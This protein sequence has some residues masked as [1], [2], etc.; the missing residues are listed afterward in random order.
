MKILARPALLASMACAILS[1]LPAFSSNVGDACTAS[2]IG[3][4][5]LDDKKENMIV[6]LMNDDGKTASWRTTAQRQRYSKTCED[7]ESAGHKSKR[8]CVQDG[9]WHLVYMNDESGNASYGDYS[10]LQTYV[11]EGAD[12]KI[13]NASDIT[14]CEKVGWRSGGVTCYSG[15]SLGA[16]TRFKKGDQV[17]DL[18]A[19][20]SADAVRADATV[21]ETGVSEQKNYSTGMHMQVGVSNLNTSY[22][23]FVKY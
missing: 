20:F 8:D 11:S 18:R 5:Q 14:H 13:A 4:A 21:I 22:A 17:D 2:D 7:W 23:W 3:K 12:V 9:R 6:C 15:L 1:P 10:E 19:V 16:D